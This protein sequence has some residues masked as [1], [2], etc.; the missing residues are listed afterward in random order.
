[1]TQSTFRRAGINYG[2]VF[3][4][5]TPGRYLHLPN[6]NSAGQRYTPTRMLEALRI[7][8]EVNIER[9]EP[10]QW[11]AVEKRDAT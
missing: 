6:P 10:G 7:A 1:M 5:L 3:V 2:V 4:E 11:P 9:W 8:G